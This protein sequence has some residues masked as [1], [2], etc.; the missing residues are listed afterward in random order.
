MEKVGQQLEWDEVGD[1]TI[2]G[3]YIP[4]TTT[5]LWYYNEFEEGDGELTFLIQNSTYTYLFVAYR[6]G[7]SPYFRKKQIK[8]SKLRNTGFAIR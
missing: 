3:T 6:D 1:V 5:N 2:K 8:T 7:Q 4:V